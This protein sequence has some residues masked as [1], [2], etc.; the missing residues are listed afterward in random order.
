MKISFDDSGKTVRLK[1]KASLVWPQ[2]ILLLTSLVLCFFIPDSLY[3][4]I[5]DA[6]TALGGGLK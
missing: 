3:Q 6:V 5:V 4:T 1:E 2:Y